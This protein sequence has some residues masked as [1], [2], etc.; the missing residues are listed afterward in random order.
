MSD[1][2]EDS[3]R[4]LAPGYALGALTPEETRAFEAALAGSPELAREVAEYRELHALLALRE[5]RTP[6]GDLKR[7][8]R[9]RIR[10]A[11]SAELGGRRD[12]A[13]GGRGSRTALALGLGLAAAGLLSVGLGLRVSGLGREL[14]ASDSLLADRGRQLAERERTLDAL[15][16]PGVLLTTLTAAGEA[17]P[18]VQLYWNRAAH[19]LV[20]HSSRLKPAPSGR[21]Y[22]LW[23]LR[24]QGAP[25]ASRL[26]NTEPGGTVLVEAIGVPEGEAIAGFALTVE[27]AGGSPQPTTTPF[28][29][30]SVPGS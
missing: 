27:P 25:I 13:P 6:P 15:L 2:R 11:K 24:K 1:A 30:G 3:L 12:I 22:Q 23:L 5:E 19:S 20:L 10:A 4:D 28:L 16:A 14:R 9:E 18:V 26:F 29:V 7:R 8:L 21:T 17:P